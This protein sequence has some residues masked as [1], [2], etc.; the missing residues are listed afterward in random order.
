VSPL[1]TYGQPRAIARLLN[2]STAQ[3]QHLR[4]R[5][6]G[7]RGEK[8]KKRRGIPNHHSS[9]ETLKEPHLNSNWHGTILLGP[10][11]MDGVP[12][13]QLF[14]G[15]S[16]A[17]PSILHSKVQQSRYGTGPLRNSGMQEANRGIRRDHY[18]PLKTTLIC[19]TADMLKC[20]FVLNW[21]DEEH[22]LPRTGEAQNAQGDYYNYT[23]LPQV[24]SFKDASRI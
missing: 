10:F 18:R 24:D 20:S 9:D 6:G 17:K 16:L 15:S 2:G 14:G 23:S 8:G 4:W 21:T 1:S 19:R 13:H 12:R 11:E 7:P 22:E 3:P 5:E